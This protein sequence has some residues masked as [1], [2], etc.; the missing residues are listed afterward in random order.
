MTPKRSHEGSH[1]APGKPPISLQE[2]PRSPEKRSPPR[3]H[4]IPLLALLLHIL[5]PAARTKTRYCAV[6]SR[7][8]FPAALLHRHG[9][10]VCR[11]QGG[12]RSPSE[13][14]K[15]SGRRKTRVRQGSSTTEEVR[16]APIRRQEVRRARVRRK[17]SVVLVPRRTQVLRLPDSSLSTKTDCSS[18]NKRAG[19]TRSATCN[20]STAAATS[21]AAIVAAGE[22]AGR[23]GGRKSKKRPSAPPPELDARTDPGEANGATTPDG[24]DPETRRGRD[25]ARPSF[26]ANLGSE[27]KIYFVS[28]A[29]LLYMLGHSPRSAT[30]GA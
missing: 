7:N 17:R 1:E 5:L 8:I 30:Q 27:E 18:T 19:R 4:G 12:D 29:Q 6:P 24:P 23:A 15:V 9:G 2:V 22:R 16:R 28:A 13:G 20:G 3:P 10:G 14:R 25:S 21:A 26:P 11:R